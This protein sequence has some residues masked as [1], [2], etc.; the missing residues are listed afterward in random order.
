MTS[1]LSGVSRRKEKISAALRKRAE[2]VHEI[3]LLD[4][5]LLSMGYPIGVLLRNTSVRLF[6]YTN[7]EIDTRATFPKDDVYALYLAWFSVVSAPPSVPLSRNVFFRELHAL[8]GDKVVLDYRPH[9]G[10]PRQ[11][12]GIARRIA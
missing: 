1:P 7:Y 5:D 10:A 3:E 6:F 2:H 12:K 9:T 4:E 11:I 8:L